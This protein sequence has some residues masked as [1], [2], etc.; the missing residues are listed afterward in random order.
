MWGLAAYVVSELLQFRVQCANLRAENHQTA[1][2]RRWLS[3]HPRQ[4]GDPVD[5]P[6]NPGAS[7]LGALWEVIFRTN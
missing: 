3:L 5:D 1:T 6:P 7:R 4:D 2:I